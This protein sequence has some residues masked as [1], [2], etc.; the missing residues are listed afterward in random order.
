MQRL[1]PDQLRRHARRAT[2]RQL[3]GDLPLS[4]RRGKRGLRARAAPQAHAW[5]VHDAV[6]RDCGTGAA[7][8]E[9]PGV[10]VHQACMELRLGV[11]RAPSD[12]LYGACAKRACVLLALSLMPALQQHFA[13]RPEDAELARDLLERVF[14]VCMPQYVRHG[15]E[16]PVE[17]V[18]DVLMLVN[19]WGGERF[20]RGAAG[21]RTQNSLCTV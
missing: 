6:W 13:A 2:L 14:P 1:H 17:L 16:L 4:K 9:D 3:L 19:A 11:L 15:G 12:S 8:G 21:Q 10:G 7:P 5:A 18:T 20:W